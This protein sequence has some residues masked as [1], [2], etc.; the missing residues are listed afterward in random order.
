MPSARQYF[1]RISIIV[2]VALF[3]GVL[4]Q[5]GPRGISWN[6]QWPTNETTAEEAYKMLAKPG[7]PSFI[8]LSDV[9]NKVKNPD[10]RF[11][12]ARSNA[13]FKA[14]HIPGA[15]NLPYYDLEAYQDSALEGLA[16]NSEIIIYC[17]GIGCELSF[18]LGRDLQEAG[19]NN[20]RIFYGGYPEWK[21]AG[22]KIER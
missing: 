18:F 10:V 12:D 19:Y 13:D 6:G 5:W 21:N 9:I 3:F 15:K 17:E 14:G 22:L 20:V 4:R 16:A 7:D 8:G 11:I 2:G 1:F